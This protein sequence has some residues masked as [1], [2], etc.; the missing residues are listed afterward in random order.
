MDRL[1]NMLSNLTKFLSIVFI[2]TART[3]LEAQTNP[4]NVANW[5]GDY[6]ARSWDGVALAGDYLYVT[7]DNLEDPGLHLLNVYNPTNPVDLGYLGSS[8]SASGIIIS[9]TTAYVGRATEIEI[10]DSS[11]RTNPVT[12]SHIDSTATAIVSGQQYLYLAA[13]SSG[14]SIY[15]VADPT[16]PAA[17][18][19]LPRAHGIAVA[20]GCAYL[21]TY[22]PSGTTGDGILVCDITDPANATNVA[23]VHTPL[24]TPEQL[25][26]SGNYLYAAAYGWHYRS[27]WIFDLSNRTNPV[28]V[29]TFYTTGRRLTVAG[30]YAY[31][32]GGSLEVYDTSDPTNAYAVANVP[33]PFN[34]GGSAIVVRQNHAYIAQSDGVGIWS[35]GNPSPPSLRIDTSANSAVVL[36]WPTPAATF[37]VQ[38]SPTLN[39]PNW[40]TVT[41][42]PSV[43]AGRN[44]V[45][46]PAPAGPM[47]YRLISE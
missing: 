37:A 41:E 42:R 44:Q 40:I 31:L 26:I 30:N 3:P 35:L 8:N 12:I 24:D 47:F 22:D 45:V 11:S 32:A 25:V 27:L 38:Q 16:N 33:L 43:V 18:G 29:K 1:P 14:S 2:L 34:E 13:W 15:S 23:F 46:L 39:P 9:G 17:L 6:W 28:P 10:L 5:Y 4:V 19:P 21:A 20:D 7:G 36:S